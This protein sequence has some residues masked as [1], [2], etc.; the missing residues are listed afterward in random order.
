MKPYL[1]SIINLIILIYV[2]ISQLSFLIFH[3]EISWMIY[4]YFEKM[5]VQFDEV[6]TSINCLKIIHKVFLEQFSLDP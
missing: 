2:L 6:A 5:N 4:Q 1:D 3:F